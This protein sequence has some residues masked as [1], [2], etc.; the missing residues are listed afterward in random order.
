[1]NQSESTEAPRFCRTFN[2]RLSEGMDEE[3][4]K[5]AL[6]TD[7]KP[8]ELIRQAIRHHLESRGARHATSPEDTP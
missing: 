1:M 2:I 3:L 8:T 7:Q 5:E 6:R 4:R